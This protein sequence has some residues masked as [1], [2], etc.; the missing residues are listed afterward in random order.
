MDD[1]YLDACY[2]VAGRIV[3]PVQGSLDW[4]G[5]RR[6]LNRK[7]LEVLALLA[8][9][10]GEMVS[11]DEFVEQIWEGNGLIGRR[12][13][14][15][16]IYTL[17]RVLQDSDAENPVI[18]TI[19]SRGYR[20]ARAAQWVGLE[21]GSSFAAGSSIARRPGWR[22]TDLLDQNEATET[23][24]ASRGGGEESRIFRFCRSEDHLRR[25]RREITVLRFL[26]EKLRD[27]D[28]IAGLLD[29]Q[30]EDP[31]YFLEMQPVV[32]GSL[33]AYADSKGGLSQIPLSERI[34]WIAEVASALEAVHSADVVHRN[35]S[36]A[37]LLMDEAGGRT[38]AKL[39]DFGL[40]NVKDPSELAPLGISLAGLTCTL[41]PGG[42]GAESLAPELRTG[43]K[44]SFASD[45]YAL[46]V[47]LFQVVQGNLQRGL[48]ANWQDSVELPTLRDLLAACV[49][50]RPEK[51][52]SAA[53]VK[54]SLE[55]FLPE[56]DCSAASAPRSPAPDSP[57]GP[58]L[59]VK[60][61]PTPT[62]PVYEGQSIGPYRLLEVLGEGGMGT[63]Y[64]AEQRRPVK[65][66][67]ALKL[68]K[69][70]MDG[71]QVL[72]RFE[73]E[74]QA[75][76]LM[77]HENVAAVYDAGSSASGHPYFVMELVPGYEIT[78]HCDRAR[79]D[80]S[81]RIELFLQ[82][83]DGVQHA[84]QKG[85]IHRD[86]K[87]SNILVKKQAGQGAAVKIID[88]GVAKS[89]QG[90]L[91]SQTLH[92]SLG[93]FVGTPLYSSPKQIS[94]HYMAVDTRSDIYS[95]GSVLYELVTGITPHSTDEL[96]GKS[97]AELVKILGKEPPPPSSR[98]SQLELSE[99][100][101][102]AENRS[103]SVSGLEQR[104]HADLSWILLKCLERDPEDRYASARELKRDL[105]RWLEGQTIEARPATGV[106]RLK[107]FVRRHRAAVALASLTTLALLTTTAVAV[108]GFLRAEDEAAKARAA[109]LEAEKAAE[110]QVRHLQS[111]DPSVMGTGFQQSLRAALRQAME[112]WGS[113][114]A[115]DEERRLDRLFQ[116]VNFTDLTLEQLD[117]NFLEPALEQI[118]A[119]YQDY[120]L[121]QA[122]LWEATAATLVEWGY[123]G[124]ALET[125]HR[126]LDRRQT[127]LGTQ[128]P[129]TLSSLHLHGYLL[130][131]SG[132]M[133]EAQGELEEA[134]SG[135]RRSLGDQNPATLAAIHD[136]AQVLRHT[137]PREESEALFLEALEG[138][139]QV[140]GEAHPETLGTLNSLGEFLAAKGRLDEAE[141]Y[142]EEALERRRLL[143]DEDHP[144][145]LESLNNQAALF[146]KQERFEE[147]AAMYR[148]A[149]KGARRLYGEEHPSTLSFRGNLALTLGYTGE[150]EE[151]EQLHRQTLKGKRRVYGDDHL[152]TL[153]TVNNLGQFLQRQGK[154]KE[155]E[156][157]LQEV[158]SHVPQ[159]V[160][161]EHGLTL[162]T[163]WGLA[164]LRKDQGR[165]D[166]AEILAR[167]LLEKYRRSRGDEHK[168]TLRAL[169][170]LGVRLL[171]Q[172]RLDEA[173]SH[174][175]EALAAQRRL[176]GDQNPETLKSLR[177]YGDLLKAKG[178]L[179]EAEASYREALAG[180]RQLYGDDGMETQITVQRFAELLRQTGR[181]AEAAA[182]DQEAPRTAQQG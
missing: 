10:Q 156:V 66:Q 160:G 54:A 44:A 117:K 32:H 16:T 155:A 126:A 169:R 41:E 127:L 30:L 115:Q 34:R 4:N 166:E 61:S 116:G 165:L 157:Y 162:S 38:C 29:W 139:R 82:V 154:L 89:L 28:N 18:R 13:L 168:H 63:V 55:A 1:R 175:K 2:E 45:V 134:V 35:L 11:R 172:G 167:E 135:L 77:D 26:R 149:L 21:R 62:A 17:R 83:C 52:P 76:A 64:L 78:E 6:S 141:P 71:E 57:G 142:L 114:E 164:A 179:D 97:S 84:H 136:L 125:Q 119:D 93:S 85:V 105:Q 181:S 174:L 151:A 147:A 7:Q 49:D 106:Y 152:L 109:A 74:R 36:P 99:K 8:G 67:V 94:D 146:H 100:A 171:D 15:D 133:E 46:G 104:L 140:L 47:L 56:K 103:Q 60:P 79:L 33:Q 124:R 137:A 19:S 24:R 42:H 86:L 43:G 178:R 87:P 102:I 148:R 5:E 111:I 176:F 22:L 9:A 81:A 131:R 58:E 80:L 25:L 72:A 23:W 144:V 20:L 59:P 96:T 69:M 53:D 88:F 180:Q 138:R 132:Q 112:E 73:A 110:F 70:G 14:T 51:R 153:V 128:A 31:P 40:G 68:V 37:G 101:V 48:P 170:R 118:E 3:D 107:K 173:E 143:Y 27:H 122:R 12:G 150:L 39:G 158:L 65:R 50:E 130:Y 121:L 129:P 108:A 163:L 90:K 182:L 91:S 98:F 177:F 145:V 120:P 92:T 113:V 75:L 123:I 161:E 95:L 159:V